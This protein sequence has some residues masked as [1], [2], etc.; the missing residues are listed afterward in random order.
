MGWMRKSNSRG[1]QQSVSQDD[2][3]YAAWRDVGIRNSGAQTIGGLL[4]CRGGRRA[5][6][7]VFMGGDTGGGLLIPYIS[8]LYQ[9]MHSMVIRDI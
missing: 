4:R 7:A 9:I 6:F 8:S 5:S 3:D 2:G 1:E